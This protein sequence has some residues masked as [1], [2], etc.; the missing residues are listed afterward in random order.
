VSKMKKLYD[1]PNGRK[2]HKTPIPTLGGLGIY[3]GFIFSF[4]IHVD[5]TKGGLHEFQYLLACFTVV[6]IFGLK[7]DILILLPM[8]KFLGQIFVTLIFLLKGGFLINSM[9][10]F[11][12]IGAVGNY[13]ALFLTAITIIVTMNAYNLIDGVDGLAGSL[14]FVSIMTFGIFFAINGNHFYALMGIVFASSI[15]A[16]LIYNYSP[17][18]IFM[19]DTGALMIGLVNAVLAIQFIQTA[20]TAPFVAIKE[21]P[22]MGF[23]IIAV[24]LLDTLRVF[25]NRM[26]QRRSPFSPDRNHLH[27]LLLDRGFT[28]KQ[29]TFFITLFQVLMIVATYFALP[30]GSSFVI[31]LQIIVFFTA[32]ILIKTKAIVRVAG[33][34][35]I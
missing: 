13:F 14:G 12:G 35:H 10:G 27:H 5:L 15:A 4:L 30:L 26:L 24:P 28:H 6:A 18:K 31:P 23:G 29:T 19:G 25:G 11:L 16:F 8:K 3:I 33:R 7:D 22:A 1:L 21:T 32:N 2:L 17:A 9:Y 34:E 20:S